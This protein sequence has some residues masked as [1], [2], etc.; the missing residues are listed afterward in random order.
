M[1]RI[2]I[3]GGGG[4]A[5][6][7]ASII[8]KSTDYEILGY[9]DNRNRG[10]LLGVSY[11]GNDSNLKRIIKKIS[12]CAAVIGV[13]SI[14]INYRREEIFEQL[15]KLGFKLPAIVSEDA[16]VNRDVKLGEG[17]VVFDGAIINAGT[18]I[19]KGVIINTNSTVEH[20]CKIGNF[21]HIAPGATLS[22]GVQI[23]SHCLIGAGTS[24]I[25]Y[26]KIANNSIIGVGAAVVKNCL[27]QGTYFGVPAK[28]KL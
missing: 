6:V 16:V 17:A 4:H 28:L 9:I 15:K 2:I 12:G 26:V 10:R 24:V 20:D 22:G 18:R 21:S 7:L 13:G 19:G 14:G 5:K 25:Q 3:V 27:K 11:L 8:E 1:T 23:G